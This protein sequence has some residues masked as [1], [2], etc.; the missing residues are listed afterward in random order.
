MIP[1]Y[2]GVLINPYPDQEGN[3]L[4]RPNYCKPL[5]K[6]SE[7]CP[8][9]LVSAAVMTSASEEKW[10]PL[11]CFFSRVGLRTYQH[12]CSSGERSTELPLAVT[13]N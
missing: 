8:S 12:P 6:N 11:N 13:D 4:Q 1:V 10:R 2:T 9:N 7:T 5:K 3:K